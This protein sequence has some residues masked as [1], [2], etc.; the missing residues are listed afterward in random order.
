M[1]ALDLLRSL[2]DESVD[3]IYTDPPFGTGDIQTLERKVSGKIV[4]KIS[5]DDRFENYMEFLVPHL[6]QIHRVLRTSGSLYLHLDWR[7]VHYAKVA[8]DRIFGFDN[9]LNEI[10]WSY[11]FGGRGRSRFP[12]KHDNILLYVKEK[13]SHVFNWNSIDRIPYSAPELQY[14][15]RSKE[16]AEKRIAAGQ[17]PTDVWSMSIV[18]TASKE[19]TDYP[20]Q[21]PVKLVKRMIVASSPSEGLIVD[22]F[23]GSGTTGAAALECGRQFILGDQSQMA[24][25]VM[26]ERFANCDVD[27]EE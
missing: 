14:V 7:W 26:K 19:R 13:G 27:F 22:P 21:K 16:E 6:E 20:T 5:Y 23:G 15:G 11:N 9:F 25:D 12:T 3:M 4:S 24:I 18:G 1:S 10:I 2:P 17:I 8:L